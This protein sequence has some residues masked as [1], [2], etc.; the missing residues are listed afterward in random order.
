MRKNIFILPAL[1]AFYSTKAQNNY[2]LHIEK[3][4]VF[5][6]GAQ[7]TNTAT[8][9][10][11][12]GQSEVVFSNVAGDIN[13]ESLTIN[14]GNGAVVESA[15]FN[16][17]YLT[18]EPLSPRAKEI[19]DTLEV[20]NNE[21]VLD[22]N[23][24]GVLTEQISVLQSN[25]TV[26]GNNTGLSVAELTKLLDLLA[27]K[28]ESYLNQKYKLETVQKKRAE[29]IALLTR[30]LEEEKQ[31]GFQPGGQIHVRFY[32]KE[33]TTC[34]VRISYVT[35]NAGWMAS[36]DIRV[37]DAG[38]PAN[39]NYKA[40]VRQNTGIVWENV[41]LAL[42]TGNP[43]EGAQAPIPKPWYLSFK[44]GG[45]QNAFSKSVPMEMLDVIQSF[46]PITQEEVGQTRLSDYVHIDNGG[47][48]TI[49]EIELPYTIANDWKQHDVTVKQYELPATY[50]Y[51]VAPKLDKEAFLQA[52]ITNWEDLN[53]IPGKTN[54]YYDGTYVG[55][56]YINISNTSDTMI[57]SLGRDKK[58]VV[59]REL[60]KQRREAKTIGT[61]VREKFAYSILVRNTRKETIQLLIQDQ[62]PVSNDKD[63]VV[64]DIET[65]GGELNET[66][67]MLR[68]Q[69]NLEPS[70]ANEIKF[71]YSVKYPRGKQVSGLH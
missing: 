64:E 43:S 25:K 21:R 37:D 3:V 36:Y 59:R 40:N 15:T 12:K 7:L 35:D 5:L 24:I 47:T 17:D 38:K 26:G 8:V 34:P 4:I 6:H 10:L 46:D 60:D 53:L 65:G 1:L 66:T 42:S 52:Q 61:N 70:Q 30:Q 41:R 57:F 55:S 18:G 48:S 13:S 31:R 54:I 63:I 58:V 29:K 33:P 9:P 19:K 27:S 11:P 23:K 20:L 22:S 62:V 49:F 2:K 67:G 69:V 39:F 44:N 68:W 14:T 28:M 50:R 45:T 16:N 51:Y 32:A 56:G 71:G